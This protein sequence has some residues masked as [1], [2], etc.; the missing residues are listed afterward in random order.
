MSGQQ[1]VISVRPRRR[2]ILEC[3]ILGRYGIFCERHNR[4]RSETGL[5]GLLKRTCALSETGSP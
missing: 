2:A 4:L 5:K 3:P 1:V